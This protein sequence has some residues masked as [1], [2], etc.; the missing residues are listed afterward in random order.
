MTFLNNSL[1]IIKI[2][3]FAFILISH[4]ACFKNSSTG[5]VTAQSQHNTKVWILER[6]PQVIHPLI[7]E[8][9]DKTYVRLKNGI[10]TIDPKLL[11]SLNTPTLYV[12][13]TDEVTAFSL[14]DGSIFLSTALIGKAASSEIF[15]AIISHELAHNLS[16]DACYSNKD[17][18]IEF[19]N[20]LRADSLGAK[21]LYAS[22]INPRAS[23][24]ALSLYNRKNLRDESDI[25][26]KKRKNEL[27]EYLD[28]FP[29]IRSEIPEE[30]L[31]R[32]VKAL[33]MTKKY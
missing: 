11:D 29:Q 23:L 22:Y 18:D 21:I 5:K 10:H 33:L 9:F 32:K 2:S 19:S 24:T 14:C 28:R 15:A 20:E 3:F 16:N 12:I 7:S 6:H 25:L 1:N 8:L 31:F 30:R 4:S 17:S 13:E 27:L 26:I